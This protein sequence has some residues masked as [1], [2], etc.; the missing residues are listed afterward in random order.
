MY[1]LVS[2]QDCSSCQNVYK[3]HTKK[4]KTKILT[5]PAVLLDEFGSNVEGTSPHNVKER[6][7]QKPIQKYKRWL[8]HPE[9]W[10]HPSHYV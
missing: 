2:A 3:N 9:R 6:T 10:H 1:D 4:T 8:N 5:A 7:Y